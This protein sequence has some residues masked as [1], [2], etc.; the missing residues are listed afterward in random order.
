MSLKGFHVFFIA[1]SVALCVGVGAWFVH[2]NNPVFGIGFIAAGAGLIGYGVYFLKKLKE[3][4]M[5]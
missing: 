5:L 1:V 4:S 3:V 2:Q